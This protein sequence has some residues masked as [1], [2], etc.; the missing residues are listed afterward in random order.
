[1]TALRRRP[2]DEG[3]TLVELLVVMIIIGILAAIAIP[4]AFRQRE[5]A[6][7]AGLKTDLRAVAEAQETY[8]T[9]HEEYLAVS[10][11]PDPVVIDSI[12]LSTGNSVAVTLNA[13]ETAFCVL[14]SNPRSPRP[15]IYVSSKGGQ[16]STSVTACP[17]S[18]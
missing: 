13:D 3:F 18:F 16:Q 14:V 17:A 11:T 4:I 6:V 9:D 2:G 1:M 8:Y 12:H 10:P 7:E 15:W 5:K